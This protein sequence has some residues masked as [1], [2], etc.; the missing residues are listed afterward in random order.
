MTNARIDALSAAQFEAETLGFL[1]MPL[2]HELH[3]SIAKHIIA[4]RKEGY[5]PYG[6][7]YKIRE[8]LEAIEPKG[9]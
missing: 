2:G 1:A 3:V 6:C 4:L 5:T 9:N 8:V 7:C